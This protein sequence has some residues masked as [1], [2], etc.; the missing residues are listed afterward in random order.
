MSGVCLVSSL[1]KWQN[2]GRWPRLRARKGKP[3]PGQWHRPVAAEARVVLPED[4]PA[5]AE[6]GALCVH[7]Q[8]RGESALHHQVPVRPGAA[9]RG[10]QHPPRGLAGGLPRADRG[11][12]VRRG[13]GEPCVLQHGRFPQGAAVIQRRVRADGAGIPVSAEQ[14]S[15]S[16]RLSTEVMC[17][18]VCDLTVKVVEAT[19]PQTRLMTFIIDVWFDVHTTT[20]IMKW[21]IIWDV[22][23]ESWLLF[24]Y[25]KQNFLILNIIILK[26]SL[27]DDTD[28]SPHACSWWL[29]LSVCHVW[30]DLTVECLR[31][32]F[33]HN[34]LMLIW[35][36]YECHNQNVANTSGGPDK[37][38]MSLKQM[39]NL[40]VNLQWPVW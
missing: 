13:G 14:A 8:L 3:P 9:V 2:N 32:Y 35:T 33:A 22:F 36:G 34:F 24:H 31:K 30:E 20:R 39:C 19:S 5:G 12:A 26:I 18:S 17:L 23:D 25:G 11:P 1:W 38:K 40:D 29:S 16:P 4:E 37:M 27:R 10:S 21:N 7:L 6:E 15:R 28:I